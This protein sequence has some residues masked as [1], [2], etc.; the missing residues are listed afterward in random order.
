MVNRD[1]LINNATSHLRKV[2]R[3]RTNRV[4][5]ADDVHVYLDRQTRRMNANQRLSVIQSIFRNGQ[6]TAVGNTASEREAARYRRITEYR[7]NG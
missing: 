2:A 5:T 3:N 7:Y 6:W 1:S 4:V